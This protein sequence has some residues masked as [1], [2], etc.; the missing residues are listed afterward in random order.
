[1]RTHEEICALLAEKFKH[2]SARLKSWGT[3]TDEKEAMS[4]AMA[5][6]RFVEALMSESRSREATRILKKIGSN[7]GPEGI[8]DYL[9]E[10]VR[11]TKAMSKAIEHLAVEME[12]KRAWQSKSEREK[13]HKHH[14]KHKEKHRGHH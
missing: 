7:G 8:Q 9:Q 1:M 5:V 14:H 11:V 3:K 10:R 6:S 13:K 12:G 2:E 4:F